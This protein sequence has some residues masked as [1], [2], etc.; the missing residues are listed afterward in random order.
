VTRERQPG[1]NI[2]L[3]TLGPI[4]PVMQL[5]QRTSGVLGVHASGGHLFVRVDGGEH[6]V[7]EIVR[8]L[9]ESGIGVVGL[10]PERDE[11]EAMFLELTRRGAP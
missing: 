11:L 4:E 1:R 8:I 5:L 9:V 10:E 7:A 3:R 6:L 2:K